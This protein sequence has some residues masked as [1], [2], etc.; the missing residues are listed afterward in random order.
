LLYDV[1][2]DGL[3]VEMVL[4]VLVIFLDGFLVCVA[5]PGGFSCCDLK[6]SFSFPP[7]VIL[8]PIS[9]LKLGAMWPLQLKKLSNKRILGSQRVKNLYCRS[10]MSE[11]LIYKLW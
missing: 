1:Q 9:L 8:T 5:E 3:F 10:P 6:S 2:K 4:E 11:I 7:V